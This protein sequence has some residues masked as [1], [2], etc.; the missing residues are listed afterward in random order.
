MVVKYQR[1]GYSWYLLSKADCISEHD[2]VGTV[3]E[4]YPL[5]WKI[6][7]LHRQI[8]QDYN[9][10]SIRLQRYEA[11]KTMNALLWMA[12]SFLYTRLESLA[13]D[14]IFEPELGLVNRK[15]LGDLL[16]FVYY[17]L[18]LAVKRILAL[19]RVYYP[20]RRINSNNGQLVIPF[21]EWW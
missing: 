1:G 13:L 21:E 10:E 16:R 20:P 4:G 12:L 17:K 3:F 15:R 18:A 19:A 11:L 5:R 9:L 2:A 7:E 14:I 6:E 8:K